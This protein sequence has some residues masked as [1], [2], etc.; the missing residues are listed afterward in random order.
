MPNIALVLSGAVSLGS[1]EAGV[2][3]ELLGQLDRLN[4]D[5]ETQDHFKID[6]ITGASAGALT[7]AMVGRAV[8]LDPDAQRSLRKAWVD[9]IDITRLLEGIPANALLSKRPI[10]DIAEP[11][12]ATPAQANPSSM[13]PPRLLM[14]FALSNMSGVDYTL[15]RSTRPGAPNPDFV[16]TVHTE[17][18]EFE[19]NDTNRLES[20]T[21]VEIR[22]AAIA[23]G[24]FPFAFAP[25]E[26]PSDEEPWMGHSLNPFPDKFTYIDGG[27]F[28]NEP[29]GEAVRLARK[30]DGTPERP[31][32][33]LTRKFLLVDANLNGS[34]RDPNFSKDSTLP[35]TVLRT[36]VVLL[37]ESSALDWLKAQRFNNEVGWRDDFLE[38][39]AGLVKDTDVVDP[40]AFLDTLEA[41]ADRIVD[42]KRDLFPGLYPADYRQQGVARTLSTFNHF[43]EDMADDRTTIFGTLA[44]LLNS[45]SGLDKKGRLDLHVIYATPDQTAG[46]RVRSFAGFFSHG[47]RLHDYKVGRRTALAELPWILEGQD[48]AYD[49]DPAVEYDSPDLGDVDMDSAPREPRE[50]LR[51]AVLEKVEELAK[52]LTL[53][54]Q[55]THW[56]DRAMVLE[57]GGEIEVER[58]TRA[59]DERGLYSLAVASPAKY[60]RICAMRSSAPGQSAATSSTF[61]RR[62]GCPRP[63]RTSSIMWFTLQ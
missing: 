62:P 30:L 31:G 34:K 40:Q 8:M 59:L 46:D 33:D 6:V 1:W 13:A 23:S 14:R 45:V 22:E 61:L 16:S 12:L 9:E 51:D 37:S 63:S 48:A 11:Y 28:N 53:G 4:R 25:H 54:P 21:W 3:D 58:P 47:W 15:S 2:L 17:R 57:E 20:A 7:A 50:R 43:T 19:L 41:A 44:F 5:R 52:G 24:N 60:S 42:Q 35:E 55:W 49:R 18:R 29:L 26:L 56:A 10:S 27:L 38:A 39:L 32:L 36:L